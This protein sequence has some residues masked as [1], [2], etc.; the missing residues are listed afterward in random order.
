MSKHYSYISDEFKAA[1]VESSEGKPQPEE[2]M[3]D[4]LIERLFATK[5]ILGSLF[6][7]R[8]LHFGTF[9]MAI[10]APESHEAIEKLDPTA[11]YNSMRA[12]LTLLS[13]PESFPNGNNSWGNG[14]AT[15]VHTPRSPPPNAPYTNI[16]KIVSAT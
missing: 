11:L 4:E 5:H 10:H 2:Q 9:D 13:G 3:P 14:E 6:N 15:Y 7:L 16:S 1:Y 12:N 8:Q